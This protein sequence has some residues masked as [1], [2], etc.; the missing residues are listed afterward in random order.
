MLVR[1]WVG[2]FGSWL[3]RVNGLISLRCREM[4]SGAP[5]RWSLE[6]KIVLT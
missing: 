5:K 1:G 6:I 2:G 3:L 4:E